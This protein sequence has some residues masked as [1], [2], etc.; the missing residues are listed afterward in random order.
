MKIYYAIITDYQGNSVLD[1]DFAATN[2]Q[3][4]AMATEYIKRVPPACGF[5]IGIKY[6][7]AKEIAKLLNMRG[8]ARVVKHFNTLL[9]L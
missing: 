9:N 8:L 4:A 5:K 7:D 2:R 6:V 3:A 1:L